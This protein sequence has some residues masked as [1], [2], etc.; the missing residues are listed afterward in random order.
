[1]RRLGL[2]PD[3]RKFLPH[4]TLARLRGASDHDVARHIAS[5]GLFRRRRFEAHEI[6]L[7]AAREPAGGPP[8]ERLA[9]Y[10]LGT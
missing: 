3:A 10:P 5:L 4:V 2:P 8:Y 7:F 9:R 1:M 6:V